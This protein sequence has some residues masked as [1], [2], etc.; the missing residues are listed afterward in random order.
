MNK[1]L[2][3]LRPYIPSA[4]TW[5]LFMINKGLPAINHDFMDADSI[6]EGSREILVNIEFLMLEIK[7]RRQR[8]AIRINNRNKRFHSFTSCLLMFRQ[9]L[10]LAFFMSHLSYAFRQRQALS[11]LTGLRHIDWNE[12]APTMNLY[13]PCKRSI[14]CFFNQ[15]TFA[16][17]R[18]VIFAL[19]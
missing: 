1:F 16:D 3:R 11:L 7:C 14:L 9:W 4:Y 6:D 15:D 18:S 12:T 19:Y 17:K 8:R 2:C 13:L 10:R 5:D